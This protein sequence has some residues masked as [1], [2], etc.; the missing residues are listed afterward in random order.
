MIFPTERCFPCLLIDLSFSTYFE[1]YESQVWGHEWKACRGSPGRIGLLSV[2]FINGSVIPGSI[3]W[4]KHGRLP[5]RVMWLGPFQAWKG[6][7]GQS[8]SVPYTL[9]WNR[10]SKKPIT[11]PRHPT[12]T[13]KSNVVDRTQ[14][15]RLQNSTDKS[16]TCSCTH[17]GQPIEA[18]VIIYTPK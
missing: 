14:D 1:T 11:S 13:I 4:L 5:Q 18:R 6:I 8:H 17:I 7:S 12:P 2:Y 10:G 9:A 3:R 16:C 15:L